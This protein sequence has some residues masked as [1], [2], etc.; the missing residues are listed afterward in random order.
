VHAS[1]SRASAAGAGW[2]SCS[3]P[4]R[5]LDDVPVGTK[6]LSWLRP[7]TLW[8]A[9]NDI[10][11]HRLH[12]PIDA[13]RAEWVKLARDRARKA[14]GDERFILRLGGADA[15]S[16]LVLGDTGEGDASQ[17]A[18]VPALLSQANGVA[19]AVICSDVIYPTG[20][21]GDYRD[22]FYR[23]YRALP[24][25]IL[26][27][28]GN[29]DW[30]DGLHGFMS[31][32]CGID[33][34][35]K[36]SGGPGA[37]GWFA[38]RLW[39]PPSSATEWDLEH[40]R[41]LRSAP[42]QMLSPPQ[43]APY[44][45]MDAGPLRFVAV[46]TGICG[47]LDADQ[48]AWLRDVSFADDRPK[49][50][51]TGKPLYVDGER[52]PCPIAD[53]GSVDDV[54][55]DARANYVAAI[56]GDIHNYQRYPVELPDGRR[57]QYIVSGGG[58]A[59]MHAT[60][61]IPKIDLEGTSEEEF[62]C[63]PLRGDSLARYSRLYDDRLT[64][65]SG[66]LR[67]TP[68]E[69]ATY[70]AELLD[71]HPT[72]GERVKLGFRARLAAR[73]IQPAPAQRGFHRFVSEAFDWNDPPMFKSFLRLDASGRELRVRCFGVSGCAGTEDAPPVE[74]ELTITL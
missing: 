15:V 13:M 14:G 71:L 67:L 12:D 27:V 3:G 17:Y 1:S 49:V 63:Y 62:R 50:L 72:R 9:R 11:A 22:K 53:G 4:G 64:G 36:A 42:E 40:M 56:G 16:L 66:A 57:V 2:E 26:A 74:D 58:G 10:I 21:T 25:P 18:V 69:A 70:M 5:W 48:G 52:H 20:R 28:P 19:A 44:W 6:P 47:R 45:A 73:V 31:H 32:L 55:R 54:V 46:D 39:N 65:G 8:A 34:T 30:Y 43:P 41:R 51:L 61:Q 35:V 7:S 60:H 29:H 59:F 37:R 38:R 33:A 24:A 23:P 68:A